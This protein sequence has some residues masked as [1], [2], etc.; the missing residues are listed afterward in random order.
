MKII[1]LL[2]GKFGKL[3]VIQQLEKRAKNG[4]VM[5][6]C[7]CEC[8]N[9]IEV[10]QYN[11]KREATK[12]CGCSS[13]PKI[14]NA[15]RYNRFEIDKNDPTV[16]IMYD[17]NNNPTLIDSED[18]EK[19]K[20]VYWHKSS[21]GY[22]QHISSKNN[23]LLHRFIMNCPD[24]KIIDHKFHDKSD[25]RKD[26]LRIVTHQENQM[27]KRPKPRKN[28]LPTGIYETPYGKFRATIRL[29][30]IK[31]YKNF[32]SLEEAIIQRKMWE[33]E[34]IGDFKFVR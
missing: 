23:M 11:L 20:L 18:I 21:N 13:R 30:E 33:D 6:L 2:N 29:K 32:D 9:T 8:G 14:P 1:N 31:K 4:N 12:D 17:G 22:W 7:Q 10:A 26:Y 27:N 28:N 34:F 19:L 15:K 5:W 3:R 24:N 16:A 25:N